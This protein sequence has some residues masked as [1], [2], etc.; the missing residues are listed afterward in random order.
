MAVVNH[1]IGL[2]NVEQS[3]LVSFKGQ[4]CYGCFATNALGSLRLA[5]PQSS[6]RKKPQLTIKLEIISNLAHHLAGVTSCWWMDDWS[7]SQDFLIGRIQQQYHG[8]VDMFLC[9]VNKP[10][11]WEDA[12]FLK[13]LRKKNQSKHSTFRDNVFGSRATEEWILLFH[14]TDFESA[15]YLKP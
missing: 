5:Q 8:N 3:I 6:R 7:I 11:S 13:N 14:L 12:N 9:G 10:G 4:Q 15:S 1:I 2:W